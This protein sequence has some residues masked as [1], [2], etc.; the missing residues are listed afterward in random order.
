[1]C[2]PRVRWSTAAAPSIVPSLQFTE[3][4][5]NRVSAI[6]IFFNHALASKT[7]LI[8]LDLTHQFLATTDVRHGLLYGSDVASSKHGE[9]APSSASI[10]R[11][12]YHEIVQFFAHTYAEVFGITA[13]P[14]THD[15]LAVFA[16]FR[17]DAFHYNKVSR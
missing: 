14:P 6:A 10:V 1:M 2:R 13:G 7:T 8:P 17:P 4:Q 12:L 11:Q 5:A 3:S 9:H 15:P 16:A